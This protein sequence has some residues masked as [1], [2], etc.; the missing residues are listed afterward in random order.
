MDP[1][2]GTPQSKIWITFTTKETGVNLPIPATYTA[3]QDNIGSSIFGTTYFY[4]F[5]ANLDASNG[6]SSYVVNGNKYILDD[7]VFWLPNLSSVV[8]GSDGSASVNITAA[9]SHSCHLNA[10]CKSS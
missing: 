8:I 5:A 4:R 3:T 10:S 9:V 7:R 6:V 2:S 1:N